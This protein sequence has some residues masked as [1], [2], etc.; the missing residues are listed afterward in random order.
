MSIRAKFDGGKKV[1]R[2]QGASWAIRCYSASLRRNLGVMWSPIACER[3]TSMP[4]SST[5]LQLYRSCSRQFDATPAFPE[6]AND[7]GRG[8]L[9][10]TARTQPGY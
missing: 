8:R 2:C 1:N 6:E 3:I 7:Q 9:R 5:F 10:E 4:P